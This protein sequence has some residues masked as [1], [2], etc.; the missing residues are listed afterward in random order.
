MEEL[1]N[2]AGNLPVLDKRKAESFFVLFMTSVMA[3][4]GHESPS[5][6]WTWCVIALFTALL[7][8]VKVWGKENAV[9]VVLWS[10]LA[11]V[12]SWL[13]GTAMVYDTK[14]L[15][16]IVLAVIPLAT[17]FVCIYSLVLMHKKRYFNVPSVDSFFLFANFLVM[18]VLVIAYR[19]LM[20]YGSW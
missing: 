8:N 4:F 3:L 12:P 10:L 1:K 7:Y 18:M 16:M 14:L 11:L 6:F 17:L 15:R 20:V 13:L 19:M 5:M 9:K 2:N